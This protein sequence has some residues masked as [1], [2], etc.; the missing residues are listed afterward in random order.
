[1]ALKKVRDRM[2][3]PTGICEVFGYADGEEK[4]LHVGTWDQCNG[5]IQNNSWRLVR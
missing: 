1:M 2:G 4:R 5:F 3:R